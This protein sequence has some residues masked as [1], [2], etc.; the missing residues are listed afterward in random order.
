MIYIFIASGL[1]LLISVLVSK[2]SKKERKLSTIIWK[3]LAFFGITTAIGFI[4]LGI[5]NTIKDFL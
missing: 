3:G 1:A 4:L 2:F 5:F